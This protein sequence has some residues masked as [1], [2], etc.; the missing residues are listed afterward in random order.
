MSGNNELIALVHRWVD[1]VGTK[2]VIKRLV[3]RG[4]APST[5]EKISHKRYQSNPR[6]LLEQVLLE[7]MAVD[8][9]V[10]KRGKAS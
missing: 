6:D 5:A 1:R 8:G 2:T 3:I 9:I 4:V 7:E 10:P